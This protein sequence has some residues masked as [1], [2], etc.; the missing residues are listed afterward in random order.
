[1]LL[2]LIEIQRFTNLFLYFSFKKLSN[3]IWLCISFLIPRTGIQRR[4]KL[5]PFFISVEISNYCNLHCPECPVGNKEF[6]TL[7]RKNFNFKLYKNLVDQLAPTLTHIILYFQ[8]EPFLNNRLMELIRYAHTAHIYTS[9]STNGQF[10]TKKNAR[11]IVLSGLDKLIV[12]VDGST[13]E[14]YE[15]YRV[16]GNLSKTIKGIK[17]VMDWK[18]KLKSSTPFVEIQFLVF[19]TNE[20]QMGDMKQLAKSLHVDNLTFKTAQLYDFEK[21]HELMPTKKRFSR[22]QMGK[23]GLFRMKGNLANHCWRLWSGAVVNA[24]GEVLPCCFDKGSDFSFGNINES[25]FSECWHSKKAVNFRK[26]ICQNRKQFE[27]CRNCTSHY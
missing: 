22:Y 9:T 2:I 19:K 11:E 26:K 16:G 13:Q 10:L 20:H 18:K 3:L 1:M 7:Q 15:N 14:V 5:L 27:M 17:Q 8:G 6:L 23:N 24:T 4:E 12:S 25:T 21:G